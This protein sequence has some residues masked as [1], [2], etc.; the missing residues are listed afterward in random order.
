SVTFDSDGK[1]TRTKS[2][3]ALRVKLD[4]LFWVNT[5]INKEGSPELS[6]PNNFK[7]YLRGLYI[8]AEAKGGK[9]S[10]IYLNLASTDAKITIYYSKDAA[11]V[12]ERT[13]ETYILNLAGTSEVSINRLNTFINN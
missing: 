12:G 9:G 10:L 6:N 13:H 4:S 3:P 7:N 8:K 11:I 1:K 2:A 5:I